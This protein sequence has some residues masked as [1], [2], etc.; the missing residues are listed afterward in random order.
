LRFL[1]GHKTVLAISR[2]KRNHLTGWANINSYR[3]Q[4]FSLS[5]QPGM[6]IA[7]AC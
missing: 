4:L 6:A 1:K 3:D 7:T 2:E 5:R